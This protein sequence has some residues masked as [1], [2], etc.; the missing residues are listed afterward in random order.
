M[1]A[2]G[3]R[4]TGQERVTVLVH[5]GGPSGIAGCPPARSGPSAPRAVHCIERRGPRA[6]AAPVS[7]TRVRMVM[8]AGSRHVRVGTR[9]PRSSPGR[10]G[11]ARDT[12]TVEHVLARGRAG[13]LLIRN[14][15]ASLRGRAGETL[16]LPGEDSRRRERDV[17][18]L[19]CDPEVARERPWVSPEKIRGDAGG[20]SGLSVATPRS[21]G[22]DLGSP[23][24]RFEETREGCQVSRLR[25]RGRAGTT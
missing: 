16:G 18:S 24:R 8:T 14:P 19:R 7:S 22:N 6:P 13:V 11:A 3:G 23:R 2:G 10:H 12:I 5:G 17:R 20:M 4:A 1:Q 21:R 15:R 9:L 25:P